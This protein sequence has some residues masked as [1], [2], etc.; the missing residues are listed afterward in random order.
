MNLLD[1]SQF[2]KD[3]LNSLL[4]QFGNDEEAFLKFAIRN[5]YYI[6]PAKVNTRWIQLK[7]MI[8]KTGEGV[9]RHTSTVFETDK[10]TATKEYSKL[11]LEENGIELLVRADRDGNAEVRKIF[12]EL[13]G[14][15]SSNGKRSNVSNYTLTHI[16]GIT[17]NPYTFTAPWNIALTSTFIAPLTD[18]KPDQ[19]HIRYLFQS[20][21]RA[22]AW[23]LYDG[24]E[25]WQEI[26]LRKKLKPTD[27]YFTLAEKLIK[28]GS[29]KVIE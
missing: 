6:N 24:V 18:G 11:C 29:V 26:I 8:D 14:I 3:G 5:V 16:W 10:K 17:D 28:N 27:E 13:T 19:A 15:L 2:N 20:T 22:I 7:G 21:F 9:I 25:G 23:L 12:K 1:G 4:E